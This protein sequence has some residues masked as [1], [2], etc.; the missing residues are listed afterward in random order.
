MA[1]DPD[2][3]QA[4]IERAR[5]AL[6]VTV[7]QL[8]VRANPKRLV[9]QGKQTLRATL[10]DTRVKIAIGAVGALVVLVVARRLFR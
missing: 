3:I 5:D 9:E 7:D 2:T 8:S 6:A 1:R 4:E 10:E